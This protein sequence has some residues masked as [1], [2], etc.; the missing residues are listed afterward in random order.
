MILIGGADFT[1]PDLLVALRSFFDTLARFLDATGTTIVDG[2]TDTG[3]MRLIAE[4]RMA[5]G[6]TF[7]LVGIAPEGAFRR[8]TRTGEPI[9]IAR[10]HDL[11]ITVPG[12]RFGD[13]TSWL[14]AAADDLGGGAAPTL[15]VN[16]GR[17]TLEEANLRLAAGHQ[18]IAVA[19]SGRAAD[20][21]ADDQ[22]L[23]GSGRLRVIP[24]DVS[25]GGLADA[26]V[27]AGQQ[28]SMLSDDWEGEPA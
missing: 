7:G 12:S 27:D 15:V 5:I 2:G 8:L 18:V 25:A 11:V 24:L 26:I 23:R 3:V 20:E 1:D 19:G 6:G 16:G 17:L 4:A 14:F 13:E 21:L 10:D 9:E 28:G 22:G